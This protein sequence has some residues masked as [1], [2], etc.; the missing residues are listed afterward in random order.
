M[1]LMKA[2]INKKTFEHHFC[3]IKV[4]EN[5]L[6]SEIVNCSGNVQKGHYYSI[7]PL[8]EGVPPNGGPGINDLE[9]SI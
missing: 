9:A 3:A 1:R 5:T 4:F 8:E 6:T 7:T 2:S